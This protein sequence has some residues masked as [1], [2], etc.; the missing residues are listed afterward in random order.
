VSR[1]VSAIQTALGPLDNLSLFKSGTAQ[2]VD[3]PAGSSTIFSYTPTPTGA[4]LPPASRLGSSFTPAA[5]ANLSSVESRF[6][7]AFSNNG[8]LTAYLYQI[9]A[10][11]IPASTL[12]AT[13]TNTVSF[14][15]GGN[16]GGVFFPAIFNF[17]SIPLTAG[18]E[19]AVIYGTTASVFYGRGTDQANTRVFTSTNTGASFAVGSAQETNWMIVNVSTP[20]VTNLVTSAEHFLAVRNLPRAYHRIAP[21]TQNMSA[22]GQILWVEINRNA[23]ANTTL[24]VNL[25]TITSF[26]PNRNRVIIARREGG[27]IY[28]GLQDLTRIAS[29][30]T[31][32]F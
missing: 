31:V 20:A 30:A 6:D 27:Q 16:P 22:D 4:F 19:Y 13:S 32:N 9:N 24:T 14:T 1:I 25:G 10:G 12:I 28:Y 21:M 17:A 23:N 26:V 8:V 18:V 11:N 2:F 15:S 5:A 7:N 29:N 3:T